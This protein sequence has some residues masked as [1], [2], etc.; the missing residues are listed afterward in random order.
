MRIDDVVE[1]E[2]EEEWGRI[3]AITL[4]YAV[5]KIWDER[6]LVLPV[7]YFLETPFQNWTRERVP[8][9]EGCCDH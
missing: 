9:V 6:R 5:V 3:E 7:S 8:T 1:E 4:T 2:E